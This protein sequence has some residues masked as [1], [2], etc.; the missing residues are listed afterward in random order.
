[1]NSLSASTMGSINKR[2]EELHKNASWGSRLPF[3]PI[4]QAL[5]PLQAFS[6]LC[7]GM[8]VFYMHDPGHITDNMRHRLN[9][10]K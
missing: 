5:M 10:E 9:F 1:M 2:R 6:W 7:P 3:P 8:P 4:P